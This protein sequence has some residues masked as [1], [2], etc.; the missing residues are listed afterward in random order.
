MR[1]VVR[2]SCK[3]A[4]DKKVPVVQVWADT[5]TERVFLKVGMITLSTIGETDEQG[6]LLFQHDSPRIVP[7]D[8][9]DSLLEAIGIPII[10]GGITPR[11]EAKEVP[12]V[13]YAYDDD[14]V[15]GN[16][17]Q[18]NYILTSDGDLDDF[19]EADYILAARIT[20]LQNGI[21]IEFDQPL[22]KQIWEPGELRGYDT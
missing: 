4:I 1:R 18:A 12:I 6:A 11:G 5:L 13:N 17:P 3:L 15:L 7:P 16:F 2:E 19:P 20:I 8:F 14:G 9:L 22:I 10:Y 21:R